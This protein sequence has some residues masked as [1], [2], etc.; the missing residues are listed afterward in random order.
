V[1]RLFAKIT[2]EQS[3]RLDVLVNNAYAGVDTIF[4]SS[5]KFFPKSLIKTVNSPVDPYLNY[6]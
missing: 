6:R 4:K 3:G 2:A 5:G 1:E